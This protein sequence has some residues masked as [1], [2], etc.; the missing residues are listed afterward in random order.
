MAD[1]ARARRSMVNGQL[2]PN[3][4]GQIR[5][6]EA[7]DSLPREKFV[8]AGQ[9]GIAY[10]DESV[11]VGPGRYLMEPMAQGR[12]IQALGLSGRELVL[13]V[14]CLTGYSTAV[15]AHLAHTVIGV[16][17]DEAMAREA[18]RLLS[19]LTIDN[20]SVNTAPHGQGYPRR[21]PYDAI[22]LEG[23][24]DHIPDALADQLREGGRLTCVL[25]TGGVMGEAMLFEKVEGHLSR[26]RLF[27]ASVPVLPGIQER[28]AFVF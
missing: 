28:P 19:D 13:D 8:P 22:V 21:G 20:A 23:M 27:E 12:L 18:N 10:I 5:L 17:Q 16:D 11:S 25:D 24:V 2:R 4:V 15:I 6:L 1:P 26:R 3:G 7:M 14:G 9:R